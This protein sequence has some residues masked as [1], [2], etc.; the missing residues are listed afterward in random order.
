M[1]IIFEFGV[2]LFDCFIYRQKVTCLKR[3]TMYGHYTGEVEDIMIDRLTV[4]SNRCA[5]N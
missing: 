5:K 2:S 1:L 4:V 3:F